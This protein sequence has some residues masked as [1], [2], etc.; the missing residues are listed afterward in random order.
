M[1]LVLTMSSFIVLV[2]L[3]Q[4]GFVDPLNQARAFVNEAGVKLH[5]AGACFELFQRIVCGVNAAH[6]HNWEGTARGVVQ[7]ADDF[8]G[9]VGERAA[10]RPPLPI[11]STSL[12]GV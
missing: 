11:D 8:G 6:A 3:G 1:V 7:V 9:T 4:N 12:S 10:A 2:L 5:Q